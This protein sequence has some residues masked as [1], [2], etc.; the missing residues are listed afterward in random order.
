MNNALFYFKQFKSDISDLH[1]VFGKDLHNADIE[2]PECVTVS[3]VIN[4]IES[5]RKGTIAKQALVDWVNVLWFTDLYVYD[6]MYEDAISSV[7][8]LLETLDEENTTFSDKE[9][10]SMITALKNNVSCEL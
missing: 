8:T 2:S 4:A 7:M 3:D 5:Y 9:Y 1:N 6:E 10:D